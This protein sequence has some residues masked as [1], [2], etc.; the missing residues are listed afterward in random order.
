MPDDFVLDSFVSNIDEIKEDAPDQSFET[1]TWTA[2]SHPVERDPKT[3]HLKISM[4]PDWGA[5]RAQKVEYGLY[6]LEPSASAESIKSLIDQTWSHFTTIHPAYNQPPPAEP[7]FFLAAGDINEF[8]LHAQYLERGPT[9]GRLIARP[10]TIFCVYYVKNDI[11]HPIPNYKTLEVLL[12]QEGLTYD[13]IKEAADD[14]YNKYDI[15]IAGSVSNT[16]NVDVD[17]SAR[18]EFTRRKLVTL[19]HQWTLTTRLR[20][21]Y[22]PKLPF[23]R[24]PGDYWSPW[25]QESSWDDNENKYVPSPYFS[26]VYTNQSW[27]E[28]LREK[29]EGKLMCK[30]D[31]GQLKMMQ[32]GQFWLVGNRDLV[33]YYN[34]LN[35]YDVE[36][37]GGWTLRTGS[38]Q[39]E[40]T[41]YLTEQGICINLSDSS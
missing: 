9:I 32:Y 3:N 5:N 27:K 26:T 11:A 12:V 21:G 30:N 22:K 6:S 37:N 17:E 15:Q 1:A 16:D 19:D 25:S 29:F 14:D 23:K 31:G 41:T 7:A 8:D 24:D 4:D 38:A 35:G 13:D 10:N 33:R 28:K 36:I 2:W 40:F 18:Q 39:Y 34:E 20:S